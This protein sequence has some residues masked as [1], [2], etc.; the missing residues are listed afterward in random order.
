MFFYSSSLPHFFFNITTA[1]LK[2]ILY[3]LHL[4][5]TYIYLQFTLLNFDTFTALGS[6][7]QTI[8]QSFI[9]QY[10]HWTIIHFHLKLIPIIIFTPYKIKPSFDLISV[11]STLYLLLTDPFPCPPSHPPSSCCIWLG[12]SVLGRCH[13]HPVLLAS[14]ALT[15]DCQQLES[16][17]GFPLLMVSPS[18]VDVPPVLFWSP[19]VSLRCPQC[20]GWTTR[21]VEV[22]FKTLLSFL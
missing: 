6:L 3:Q 17:V 5:F 16:S 7:H 20:Q 10:I 2:A 19:V 18:L 11:L 21:V 1:N 22:R 15:P 12:W 9:L 14:T 8:L 4:W 13:M